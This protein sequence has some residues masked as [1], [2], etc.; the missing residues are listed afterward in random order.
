MERAGVPVSP[1]SREPVFDVAA[2]VA[3]AKRIG[4]PVMVKAAAGGGVFGMGVATD[5]AG[6]R[7]AFDR[8]LARGTVLRLAGDLHR[9]IRGT[10]QACRSADPRPG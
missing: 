7:S 6:L 2:A 3:E 1:A 5:E 10:R 4:Y 8:P 9:A